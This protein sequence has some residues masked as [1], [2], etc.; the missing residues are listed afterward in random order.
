MVEPADIDA[1]CRKPL[2]LVLQRRLQFGRRLVPFG[3]VIEFDDVA[4]GIAA[5]KRRP[6]PHVAVDPADVEAG[7]LQRGDAALQR[8]RAAGAQRHVLHPGGL[9]RRQLQRIALVIVPAAQIDRLAL[10]A[11]DGHA[12]DVDEEFQALVRFWRQHF[13]MAEMGE[14]EDRL[15][16]HCVAPDLGRRAPRKRSVP[17]RR[18]FSTDRCAAAYWVMPP[19]PRRQRTRL[20]KRP[21]HVVEQFVDGERTRNELLLRGIIDDQ[22]QRTLHLASVKSRRGG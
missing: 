15:W 17:V 21:R 16:G 8:L 14:I 6:L 7:T 11:A 1:A 9:G 22:F 20:L 3:L 2:R 18:A 13:H 4:V 19:S 12:H 5:A 10:L